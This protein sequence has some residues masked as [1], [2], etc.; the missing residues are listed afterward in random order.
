MSGLPNNGSTVYV[1]LYSVIGGP[2]LSNTY[3]YTT[4]P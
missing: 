2:W 1:T 3:T 4:A